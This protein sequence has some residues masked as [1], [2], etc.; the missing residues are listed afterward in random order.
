MRS[1]RPAALEDYEF[2]ARVYPQ[3]EARTGAPSTDW[4]ESVHANVLL[5]EEDGTP[6]GFIYGYRGF[7]THLVVDAAARGRGVGRMLMNEMARR[8][9]DQGHSFWKLNVKKEN[10]PA[11]ALYRKCGL[12]VAREDVD[13]EI[14]WNEIP[15]CA[16]ST[17]ITIQ[18]SGTKG[19]WAARDNQWI[20]VVALTEPHIVHVSTEEH[21]V[22]PYL[23]SLLS[24]SGH[25]GRTKARAKVEGDPALVQAL[26]SIGGRVVLRLFQM[27]GRL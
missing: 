4:W 15:E 10:A 1:V 11:I 12:A 21:D 13:V 3:L 25:E 26:E 22:V 16:P 19:V 6:L 20:A 14:A 9:R 24:K 17:G 18:W 5:A 2:F 23:F 27:F 8:F 7:V